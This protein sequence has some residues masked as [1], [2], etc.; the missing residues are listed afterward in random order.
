MQRLTLFGTGVLLLGTFA[1][2][3]WAGEP[4]KADMDFCNKKAAEV[5]TPSPVQPGSST[6]ATTPPPAGTVTPGTPVS[7]GP[8]VQPSPGSGSGQIGKSP[9][10]GRITDSSQPG[11]APSARGMAPIGEKDLK[12]RQAYLACLDARVK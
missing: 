10:G 4:T 2:P 11:I 8:V 3:A 5:S 6:Q 7:P 9:S 12:Y 1:C